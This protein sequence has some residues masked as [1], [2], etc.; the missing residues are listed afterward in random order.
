MHADAFPKWELACGR[1]RLDTSLYGDLCDSIV[2]RNPDVVGFTALAC[3]FILVV[4]VATE[5]KRR[6]PDLPILVGGPQATILHERILQHFPDFDVVVRNEAEHTLSPLLD[7][8]SDRSFSE[9]PGVSYRTVAGDAVCNSG[10]PLIAD[11]DELPFPAFDA[12][13]IAELGLNRMRVEAGR[14]CPFSC[15]F[16]STATFFGRRYRLKS[17]ARL[18]AEMDHLNR[19]YGFT[20]FGLTHDLFT[21]NRKKVKEFC[22][23][24]QGRGYTWTCSARVD[25]VDG[26]LLHAMAKA[27]CRDIYFGIETGSRRMQEISGKRLDIDLVEPTVALAARLGMETTT[28]FI[29][30]YPEEETADQAATLDLAGRLALRPDGKTTGQLHMLTPEPGTALMAQYGDQMQF[31]GHLTDY[32]F[33]LLEPGDEEMVARA[34]DLFANYHY[35]PTVLPRERHILAIACFDVLRD[36]SRPIVRYLFRGYEGRVS[37]LIDAVD[38]WRRACGTAEAPID[39]GLFVAFAAARFGRSHHLVSLLR[40]AAAIH[41]VRIAAKGG[42]AS[43]LKPRRQ[44]C[45]RLGR[46]SEILV[47]V[48]NCPALLAT[49]ERE[50]AIDWLDDRRSG[51]LTCLLL[52]ANRATDEIATF[53][54]DGAVAKLLGKFAEPMSYNKFR[55]EVARGGA[56]AAWTWPDLRELCEEGVLETAA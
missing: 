26:E 18:V 41:R 1:L 8:I 46:C 5:L 50:E 33:P 20:D 16:C 3:N 2:R 27:G 52:Q 11:L 36:L 45:L 53:E 15:T 31:D 43:S 49:I 6:L 17:T 37:V 44:A 29:T 28:S 47:D 19:I 23:A 38:S 14:G 12:Y 21:V 13:P 32:N 40:Y 48:H 7:H 4:R 35:Y 55:R 22:D 24:V 34:P 56:G 54:I 25:C 9:L 30:G 10:A 51:T 42:G 39:A